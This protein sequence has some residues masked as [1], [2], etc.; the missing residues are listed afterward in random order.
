MSELAMEQTLE[1]AKSYMQSSDYTRA[2]V[3]L[4]RVCLQWG[5]NVTCLL[6]LHL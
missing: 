6:T 3:L 4:S 5:P 2:I 1:K